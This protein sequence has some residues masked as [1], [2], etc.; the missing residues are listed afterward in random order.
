MPTSSSSS[1]SDAVIVNGSLSLSAEAVTDE[2]V[3]DSYAYSSLEGRATAQIEASAVTIAGDTSITGFGDSGLYI[4]SVGDVSTGDIA[5]D[6]RAAAYSESGDGYSSE[7]QYGLAYLQISG[8]DSS[9]IRSSLDVAQC[10]RLPFRPTIGLHPC[11]VH[12]AA[13]SASSAA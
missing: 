2:F 5:I 6:A 9:R 11:S 12:A 4:G 1:S 7:E 10:H 13:T 8:G 3:G